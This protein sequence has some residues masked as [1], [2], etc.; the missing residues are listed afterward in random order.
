MSWPIELPTHIPKT[1]PRL[2]DEPPE[3]AALLARI[4]TCGW[5]AAV[6]YDATAWSGEQLG[7]CLAPGSPLAD[8]DDR[9]FVGLKRLPI[10]AGQMITVLHL[11]RDGRRH[12]MAMGYKPVHTEFERLRDRWGTRA[13]AHHGQTILFAA[14]ARRLGYQAEVGVAVP[15]QCLYADVGLTGDDGTEA[16]CLVESGTPRDSHPLDRWHRLGQCQPFLPLV[17]PDRETMHRLR[18]QARPHIYRVLLTNLDDLI[19]HAGNGKHRLWLDDLNRFREA[20]RGRNRIVPGLR[21]R[22]A[23][24]FQGHARARTAYRRQQQDEGVN[25]NSS[26][27]S[28]VI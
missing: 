12:L 4:G 15:G 5:S 3:W 18:E 16:W 11:T 23:F 21:S 22:L 20:D 8:L 17:T 25:G 10:G 26:P 24:Q 9:G 2:P 6:A 14:L 1:D 27:P 19:L 7:A 28:H 13:E